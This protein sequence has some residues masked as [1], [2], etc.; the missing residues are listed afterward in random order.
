MLAP[1]S[2]SKDLSA[3][4]RL[5]AAQGLFTEANPILYRHSDKGEGSGQTPEPVTGEGG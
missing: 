2:D 4:T 1:R 3:G 5:G